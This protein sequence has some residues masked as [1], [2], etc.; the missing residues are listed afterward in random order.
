M[1]QDSHLVLM[2][3]PFQN[4]SG[5]TNVRTP[6]RYHF[7]PIQQLIS[8]CSTIFLSSKKIIN[9]FQMALKNPTHYFVGHFN[10][11]YISL[12]GYGLS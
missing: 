6:S 10:R 8:N 3:N 5:L 1:L 2:L 11:L 7:F 4:P 9:Y 12:K